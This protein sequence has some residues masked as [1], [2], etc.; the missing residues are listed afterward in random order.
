MKFQYPARY[1]TALLMSGNL[2]WFIQ[3]GK[4]EDHEDVNLTELTA[5][6]LRFIDEYMKCGNKRQAMLNAGYKGKGKRSTV[7]SSV[8]KLN[9]P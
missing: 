6:Q 3:E 7:T 5:Y 8:A 2:V 1:L 9:V 4:M